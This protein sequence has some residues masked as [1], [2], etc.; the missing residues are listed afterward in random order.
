MNKTIAA[1][2]F[3]ILVCAVFLGAS[4]A[5]DPDIVRIERALRK[6]KGNRKKVYANARSVVHKANGTFMSVFPDVCKTPT[7]GRPIPIPYP[8][9][10]KSND[11]SQGS[12]K[13]KAD[14]AAIIAKNSDIKKSES[15][16][17]ATRMKNLQ[18]RYKNI[19][20]KRNISAKEKTSIKKEL[21]ACLDK[22]RILKK[23]LDKYVEELEKLLKQA[24][25]NSN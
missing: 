13:V 18:R 11:T 6:T 10:S 5:K 3:V 7:P 22:S 2:T 14:R 24:K 12:K 9:I 21:R 1:K 17:T 19:I 23:T 4:I 20:A 16:E 8:N 25:A 15:D